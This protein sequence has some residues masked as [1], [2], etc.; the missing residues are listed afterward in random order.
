MERN[1]RSATVLFGELRPGVEL[2]IVGG[3]VGRESDER[4]FLLG[5]ATDLR[6]VAAVFRG[7]DLGGGERIVIAVGPAKIVAFPYS[8]ELLSRKLGTLCVGI[9]IAPESRQL[10]PA[11]DHAE[12]DPGGVCSEGHGVPEPRCKPRPV[13][14]GLVRGLGIES[15]D[16]S[17]G[18]Q[19]RARVQAGHTYSSGLPLA[20]I[21]RRADVHIKISIG[22]E[23]QALR[24]VAGF[25]GEAADDGVRWSCRFCGSRRNPILEDGVIR[26]EP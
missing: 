23:G 10:I 3:P 18:L 1:E 19:L 15:P 11:V 12:E 5:A 25:V 26:G 14:L 2:Q 17:P 16:P 13:F 24:S 7:Q 8:H 22:A 21:G 20:R 9:K 4:I 6:T